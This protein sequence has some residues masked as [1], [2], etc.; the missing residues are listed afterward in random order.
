MT[1]QQSGFD[2]EAVLA[3]A[4]AQRQWQLPQ[5]WREGVLANLN[6]IHGMLTDLQALEPEA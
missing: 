6:R 3:E 4:L 1:E 5:A 2:A